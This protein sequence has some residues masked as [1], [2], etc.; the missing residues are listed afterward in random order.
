LAGISY[1]KRGSAMMIALTALVTAGLVVGLGYSQFTQSKQHQ[2][3]RI[4]QINWEI[5]ADNIRANMHDPNLCKAILQTQTTASLAS[6]PS[7][8]M[9]LMNVS[10]PIA[11]DF[12]VGPLVKIGDIKASLGNPLGGGTIEDI[13]RN[14]T[15]GERLHLRTLELTL[16][17]FSKTPLN[18]NR[19]FSSGARDDTY[20]I[21]VTAMLDDSGAVKGCYGKG[22]M[23][24]L[25]HQI[26]GTYE[27][28]PGLPKSCQPFRSTVLGALVPSAASCPPPY[29]AVRVSTTKTYVNLDSNYGAFKSVKTA[30]EH[31]ICEWA[32]PYVSV[33]DTSAR[34][35]L[36]SSDPA[37]AFTAM[38]DAVMELYNA[39]DPAQ[40]LLLIELLTMDYFE[41]AKASL[42]QEQGE[43]DEAFE[44]RA[45]QLAETMEAARTEEI[46]NILKAQLPEGTIDLAASLEDLFNEEELGVIAELLK[47]D[48]ADIQKLASYTRVEAEMKQ[49]YQNSPEEIVLISKYISPSTTPSE[50]EAILQQLGP[51]VF[52]AA[53]TNVL[54]RVSSAEDQ[55][56]LSKMLG[57]GDEAKAQQEIDTF[58]ETIEGI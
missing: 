40:R 4:S 43:T 38:I 1:S 22:S 42:K 10:G 41:Q 46:M 24:D 30:P 53:L 32:N 19:L 56:L 27:E 8:N 33:N 54:G 37:A 20:K 18:T 58:F 48:A 45:A 2:A 35:P 57:Y 31:F 12:S 14:S 16:I 3:G 52:Q 5:F 51:E 21:K 17:P 55:S 44:E 23:A 13:K 26:G 7:L 25:C 6:S 11:K 34:E 49:L 28:N 47:E 29:R 50:R 9:G 15:S 39:T 36:N